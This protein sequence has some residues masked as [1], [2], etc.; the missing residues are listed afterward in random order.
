MT[1]YDAFY[2]SAKG[3][4]MPPYIKWTSII[5]TEPF[6]STS[7]IFFIKTTSLTSLQT[8]MAKPGLSLEPL[9]I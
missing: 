5:N 3:L 7:T 9:V 8:A 6:H 2:S 4:E 1:K